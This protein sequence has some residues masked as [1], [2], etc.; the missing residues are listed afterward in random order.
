MND[1]HIELLSPANAD[2]F[3]FLIRFILQKI[4]ILFCY[5]LYSKGILLDLL[6]LCQLGR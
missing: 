3:F 5:Q 1:Y 6:I 2:P 4:L